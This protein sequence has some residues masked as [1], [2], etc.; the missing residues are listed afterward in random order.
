MPLVPDKECPASF[1]SQVSNNAQEL[2]YRISGK[3]L[4]KVV[5]LRG[6][7]V[8]CHSLLVPGCFEALLASI[9]RL[10]KLSSDGDPIIPLPTLRCSY[11]HLQEVFPMVYLIFPFCKLQPLPSVHSSANAK[12]SSFLYIC[13]NFSFLRTSTQVVLLKISV[14]AESFAA[15]PIL[16]QIDIWAD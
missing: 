11:L 15:F 10:L 12:N 1:A 16:T 6:I 4:L 3:R 13:N 8:P 7:P 9:C 2:N 14:R 5:T